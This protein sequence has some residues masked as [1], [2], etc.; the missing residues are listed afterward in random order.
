MSSSK[1]SVEGTKDRLELIKQRHREL[2][3]DPRE[4]L[5]DGLL[6]DDETFDALDEHREMDYYGDYAT[7]EMEL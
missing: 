1:R 6:E 2:I 7:T 5:M 4:D 3:L